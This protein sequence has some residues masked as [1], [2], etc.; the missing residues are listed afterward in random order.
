M[1]RFPRSRAS[2]HPISFFLRRNISRCLSDHTLLLVV[3][4]L[5]PY[6]AK[7]PLCR[8]EIEDSRGVLLQQLVHTPLLSSH[9]QP[10][11]K[12]YLSIS[13]LP[14][15]AATVIVH[16]SHSQCFTSLAHLSNSSLFVPAT[17]SKTRLDLS[18]FLSYLSLPRACYS[19]PIPTSKWMNI[20][21]QLT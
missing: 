5:F 7:V 20:R 11:E 2:N 1:Q 4:L 3:P 19:T 15:T 21:E 10:L 12:Q 13:R 14:L 6:L 8:Q 17:S 18:L 16:S 9:G